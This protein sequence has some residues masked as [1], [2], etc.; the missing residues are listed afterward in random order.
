MDDA[1]IVQA[2][3]RAMAG[4]NTVAISAGDAEKVVAVKQLVAALANALIESNKKAPAKGRK[5]G[6][7]SK[8]ASG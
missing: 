4:L 7:A 6:P 2:V 3:E 5:K 8:E 1:T